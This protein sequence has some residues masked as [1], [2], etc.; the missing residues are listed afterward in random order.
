MDI[1]KLQEQRHTL[2]HFEEFRQFNQ[3]FF[4]VDKCG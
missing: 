1:I 2:F 4:R 3:E